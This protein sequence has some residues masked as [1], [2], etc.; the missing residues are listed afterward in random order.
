MDSQLNQHLNQPHL[1]LKTTNINCK[2][3]I[4]VDF[5]EN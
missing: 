1:H 2:S 4:I 5:I 3:K